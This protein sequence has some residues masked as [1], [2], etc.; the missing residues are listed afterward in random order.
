FQFE[1]AT[2]RLEKIATP[3]EALLAEPMGRG[4][5]LQDGRVVFIRGNNRGI[6]IADTSLQGAQ[7]LDAK[8]G[9]A[10]TAIIGAAL[11]ADDG[12]WL[13]T[14]NGLLRLDLTPGVTVFDERNAF[15]I[16]S[17]SSLVRH[18]GVLY[19]ASLQGLMRLA[20]GEPASG[21]PARFVP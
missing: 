21:K 3:L 16:G 14:G 6:L 12:L 13:G 8:N 20:P 10:N 7:V 9:L 15:P 5:R 18:G 11:D 19:A 2:G 17:A 4:L 1:L